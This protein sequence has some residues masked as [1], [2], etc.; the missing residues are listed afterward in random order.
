ML[1]PRRTEAPVL[2]FTDGACEPDCTSIG[3][4]LLDGETVEYFGARI[5]LPL[6]KKWCTKDGQ[7]QVIGQAELFPVLVARLT[8][9][10]K[11]KGRR[12]L[13]FLDNES[14]RLGLV[15]AYSPVLP[16]LE[17]IMQCLE[18][19]YAFAVDAWYA[20]VPTASNISDGPSR[21]SAR[22]IS[23]RYGGRSIRPVFPGDI[24][25]EETL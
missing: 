12:V 9:K 16:S 19:D 1:G 6:C 20:R 7:T 17:I 3:G 11:L 24:Q 25:P 10:S 13:F 18:W 22:Y 21:M 14:A 23:G 2:V 8:W 5:P 4:V 15:K